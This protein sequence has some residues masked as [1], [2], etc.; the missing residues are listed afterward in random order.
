MSFIELFYKALEN[1][2]E[3]EGLAMMKT[4]TLD[5]DYV[6]DKNHNLLEIALQ[7]NKIK[8]S[9]YLFIRGVSIS[10]NDY[11]PFRLA[12]GSGNLSLVELMVQKDANC[13]SSSNYGA[14][15]TAATHGH[16]KILKYLTEKDS[17]GIQ[18]G[19]YLSFR[20]AVYGGRRDIVK[21]LYEKD[22]KCLQT[23]TPT[24]VE[25][26]KDIFNRVI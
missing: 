17:R 13:I 9:T 22:V 6:N 11:Q 20:V 25:T 21:Y 2:N 26:Y 1:L 3:D 10:S 8:I 23:L 14:F 15:C 16:M 18:A 4:L 5:K 7:Y 24:M 19:N 12:V